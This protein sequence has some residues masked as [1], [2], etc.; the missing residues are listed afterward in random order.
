MQYLLPSTW[1]IVLE[2]NKEMTIIKYHKNGLEEKTITFGA[3]T[4]YTV[5]I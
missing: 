2:W 5:R 3:A 4:F 1:S